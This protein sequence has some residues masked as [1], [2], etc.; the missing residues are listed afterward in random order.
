MT[1]MV[2]VVAVAPLL[3]LAEDTDDPQMRLA[4]LDAA[5][6]FP[7]DEEAW[8]RYAGVLGKVIRDETPALRS[9]ALTLA[10]RVPLLSVREHLR[11]LTED[12]TDPDRDAVA[13]ALAQV[14]DVSQVRNLL[15]QA[16]AG[17]EAAFALLATTPLEDALV[18][19]DQIPTP[20]PVASG[21]TR[22]WHALVL[23]RLGDYG[24]LDAILAGEEPEPELFWGSPWTA[25][26][27]I[28]AIRPVPDAMHDQLLAILALLGESEQARLAQLTVWAVTG[29][30][31]AEGTPP[32]INV[33]VDAAASPSAVQ[34]AQAIAVAEQLPEQLF[35]N[36]LSSEE[37]ATLSQL[38]SERVAGLVI[39]TVIAGNR[40][41]Q[42]AYAGHAGVFIEPL[43]GNEVIDL[44]DRLPRT[45]DW[46]VA[47]LAE[48]QILTNYP[49]LD[50][51]QMAWVIARDRPERVIRELTRLLN[52]PRPTHDQL[53]ILQLLRGAGDYYA[54]RGCSPWRG[55]GAS[56]G[57]APAIGRGPLIDDQLDTAIRAPTSTAPDGYGY[58]E[59]E[60]A[61][62]EPAFDAPTELSVDDAAKFEVGQLPSRDRGLAIDPGNVE[63][64]RDDGFA[65][66]TASPE[67]PDLQPDE[68]ET[69]EQPEQDP[70]RVHAQIRHD[71]Q[72]R[73]SFV[74]GADNVIRCWIGLKAPEH[75]AVS[76]RHIPHVTIPA[77]GLP[78]EVELCWGD[79]HDR[80]SLLLPENRTAR[81][82]D[83][84]L[85]I[86]VPEGKREV[87][88]L[89]LFRYRGRAFEVVQVSA[90]ALAPGEP[91]QPEHVVQVRVQASLR[92]VID[93]PDRIPYDT[94]AV[95]LHD[96]GEPPD[97]QQ[98]P[99]ATLWMFGGAGAN[100][101]DLEGTEAA[102]EWLNQD[103]FTTQK[104]LVRRRA[105]QGAGAAGDLLDAKDPDVLR[106][107][108][109]M[110]RHGSAIHK[111]LRAGICKDPGERIQLLNLEPS[112]YVPL[113]FV[114]D[115]GYPADDARLCDGWLAAL[116]SDAPTCPTCSQLTLTPRQLRWTPA[117]CPL[118]FWSLQKIIER[119][120]PAGAVPETGTAHPSA[121]NP[122]RRKLPVIDDTVF[123]SS[124]YVPVEERQ[125]TR[126]ALQ[127]QFTHPGLADDWDQWL[128]A[129]E[130]RYRPLL[131]MLPHHDAVAGLDFLEIGDEQLPPLKG[132]LSRGQ[133]DEYYINP[134]GIE[135]GPIVLLLGCRTGAPTEVGYVQ[136][137]R[138]FQQL[139]ASIV[140][141]TLAQVLGRHA[142]PVARE[143]VTQLLAV[144][145][146][147]A[148]FGSIMRRVRRR[149]LAKGYLMA[150]C[151]VALGDAD[152]HLTP[153]NAPGN[154][155]ADGP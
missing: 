129:L 117:I 77:G 138:S 84:D 115:R 18:S 144:E 73:N 85:N 53:H 3:A 143:L 154:V 140:V 90:K 153:R 30:A 104:S 44:V 93:L 33:P 35:D 118:G 12:L 5:S 31:D 50:D 4:A 151:L 109:D 142:A 126:D 103:L 65:Y 135:P 36:A 95:S 124:H 28:A 134:A 88:V 99:S 123:A 108:R 128:D 52:T 74:V 102:L 61:A 38:P 54:G 25:Y 146:A 78:L 139:R 81:T 24:L 105:S 14:G 37:L 150:L 145:D 86:H 114:Y 147:D 75:A 23:A 42:T 22:F 10:T 27:A 82:A 40:R 141:G 48:Q 71:G 62:G 96:D 60:M 76:D 1:E 46:P 83:C 127:Q 136:L 58:I 16:E 87:S 100:R 120:D 55:A 56:T 51:D 34:V 111:Q 106:L 97:A 89:I 69:T 131:V 8:Q 72:R 148:D 19:T 92:E 26:D 13:R 130:E 66:T 64:E 6:R 79:Q 57:G 113:E 41:M 137:A 107:L 20:P 119:R 132:H 45:D 155:R 101:Y 2:D 116:Q 149:M 110:A 59:E 98:A 32:T 9:A 94:C 43:L 125:A 15:A 133:L 67:S 29:I 21:T 122:A 112:A 63:Y 11:D 39:E 152:W 91:E 70:R 121:P 49:I 47:A 68:T 17:D 7:L 80:K